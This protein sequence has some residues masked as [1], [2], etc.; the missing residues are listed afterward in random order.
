MG[1]MTVWLIVQTRTLGMGTVDICLHTV[2]LAMWVFR[3]W[4]SPPLGSQVG[5]EASKGPRPAWVASAC[6][7]MSPNIVIFH[8]CYIKK[9]VDCDHWFEA[10]VIHPWPRS[11]FPLAVKNFEKIGSRSSNQEV[12]YKHLNFS[13]VLGERGKEYLSVHAISIFYP[14]NNVMGQNS[15]WG[16]LTYL[17]YP[18]IPD[19][20]LSVLLLLVG[21][22]EEILLQF[23]DEQSARFTSPP[24]HTIPLIT[25]YHYLHG[26]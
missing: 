2:T 19:G 7:H 4:S 23:Q 11:M 1:M 5:S 3:Y 15:P 13:F 20:P 8:V 18:W 24:F 16:S 26:T 10:K 9:Y 25:T 17:S 6:C 14:R 22:P 12:G 21:T